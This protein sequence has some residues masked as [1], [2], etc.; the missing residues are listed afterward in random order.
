MTKVLL[1]LILTFS[2]FAMAD[3]VPHCWRADL[4]DADIED[5]LFRVL[6][7]T[8]NHHAQEVALMLAILSHALV[9]QVGVGTPDTLEF[10]E[11]DVLAPTQ[12]WQPSAAFPTL[13]S[14]KAYILKTIEPVL[15]EPG[16]RVS[17]ARVNHHHPPTH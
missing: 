10:I 17:C 2:S 15:T 16:V 9:S 7:P 8:A 11:V 6:M 13:E 4:P 1:A 5:G 14:F 3:G 12:H